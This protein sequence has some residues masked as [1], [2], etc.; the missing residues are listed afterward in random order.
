MFIVCFEVS[1]ILGVCV[2]CWLVGWGGL[3]FGLLACWIVFVGLVMLYF[4]WL[5][6]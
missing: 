4:V 6:V 3:R 1:L 2:V 5:L